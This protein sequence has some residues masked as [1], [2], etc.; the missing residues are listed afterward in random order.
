MIN[1]N[2]DEIIEN[3]RSFLRSCVDLLIQELSKIA[4]FRSQANMT[5]LLIQCPDT[6]GSSLS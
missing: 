2:I 5:I 1:M 3:E 6:E 4:H